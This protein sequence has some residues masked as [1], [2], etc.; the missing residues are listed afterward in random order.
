MYEEITATNIIDFI[1]TRNNASNLTA[2]DINVS[3]LSL[4]GATIT[5]QINYQGNVTLQFRNCKPNTYFY[6]TTASGA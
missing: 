2:S 4:T 6:K 3:G 5:G 1:N